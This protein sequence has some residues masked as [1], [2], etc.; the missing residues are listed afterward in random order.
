MRYLAKKVRWVSDLD[1]DGYGYDVE[2][3]ET[4]GQQ[5]LLEIKTT[6]GNERTRSG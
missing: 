3:F 2:S 6:C 1:G 5:R 4:D